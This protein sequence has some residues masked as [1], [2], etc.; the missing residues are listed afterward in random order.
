MSNIE[1]K[2]SELGLSLP[3]VTLPAAN[4]VPVVI[5]GS[6]LVV[7]GQLPMQNGKF[8]YVGKVGREVSIEDAQACAKLC[9]LNV[10]AHT[11]KALGD[12]WSRLVRLVRLGVF[13]NATDEFVDH[14][15]VA[16]GASDLM[17]ALLGDAGRH[18]R[19][20]VGM[21]SLPFGV[22]VEVEALFEVR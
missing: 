20:A 19:C 21:G 5:T 12:D 2:L 9:A 22:A 13:V 15:K 7:S 10:L 1:T 3:E 6:Q 18:A 11:K 14:P 4:Y 8:H 16:N 17:V